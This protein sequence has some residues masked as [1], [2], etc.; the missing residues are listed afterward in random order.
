MRN[1]TQ[2]EWRDIKGY[3]GHYQISNYGNIRSVKKAPLVLKKSYQKNGYE[4]VC[5]WL[6]GKKK[7]YLVHRL[8]ANAFLSNPLHFSDV[9]H[10][11]ENKR[12]NRIE[13]LEW[14]THLFNMNFGNVKEK[15]GK[16][17]SGRIVSE[18]TKEKLRIDT[19]HRK[20]IHNG[21]KEKYVHIEDIPYYTD[22]GWNMGRTKIERRRACV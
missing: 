22:L 11:D 4:Y 5:L 13:N 12:N 15:I 18:D 3:E 17:N 21:E 10:I 19:S 8:A 6:H 16:A 14:C 7:N 1:R 20:W 9:N 2:E